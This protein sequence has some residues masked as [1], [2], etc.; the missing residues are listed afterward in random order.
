MRGEVLHQRQALRV[1]Q[2]DGDRLLVG[3]EQQ[4]I[5]IVRAGLAA[6]RAAGIAA[7]GVFQLDHVG[8]E[9]GER[10]GA[11]RSCFELGEIEDLHPL[12][13]GLSV[14]HVGRS[15][16]PRERKATAKP[17][18]SHPSERWS[19]VRGQVFSGRLIGR[20]TAAVIVRTP[21]ALNEF[22]IGTE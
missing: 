6:E 8:A 9:P 5:G 4:E 22:S 19:G 16:V 21:A 7:A 2:I 15:S 18:G 17:L 14:C 20:R 12:E 11:G 13:T 1:L 3:V 10:L